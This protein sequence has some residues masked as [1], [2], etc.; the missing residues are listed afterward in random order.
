MMGTSRTFTDE[1]KVEAIMLVTDQGLSFTEAAH[2][3]GITDGL[4]RTWKQTLDGDADQ[5][6]PGHGNSTPVEEELQ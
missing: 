3:L 1:V 6:F 2:K 5:A 4:L